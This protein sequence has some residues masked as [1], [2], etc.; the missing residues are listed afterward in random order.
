[1]LLL[2]LGPSCRPRDLRSPADMVIVTVPASCTGEASDLSCCAPSPCD[3]LTA[4]LTKLHLASQV[5]LKRQP[6]WEALA[7]SAKDPEPEGA[8]APSR[9]GTP[10]SGPV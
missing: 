6:L 3:V 7:C 1:M 9:K 2:P 8:V 10:V 5:L 4:A